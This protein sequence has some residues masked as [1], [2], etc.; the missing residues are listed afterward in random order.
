MPASEDKLLEGAIEGDAD[1]IRDIL[2]L[3]A[4]SVRLHIAKNFSR[5]WR[6]LL[7]EDDVMQ[8]TYADVL[9]SIKRFVP[10]GKGSFQGWL[11]KLA[12]CNLRDAVKMLE[13]E[14]RGGDRRRIE[15]VQR[16]ESHVTLLRVL[17]ARGQSPTQ[18]VSNKEVFSIL[19]QTVNKLP[20]SYRTVIRMYD[21]EG[22]PIEQITKALKRSAGAVYMLRARAHDRLRNLLGNASQYFSNAT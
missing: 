1:S 12:I 15:M 4:P 13:A 2:K 8:Q 7:S 16:G 5:R 14:K 10:V 9:H 17:T 3:H 6:S 11:K 21:L 20:E 18:V 22:K 19:E